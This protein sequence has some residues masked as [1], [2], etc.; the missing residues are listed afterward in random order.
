LASNFQGLSTTKRHARANGINAGADGN[1]VG[2]IVGGI[3]EDLFG[4]FASEVCASLEHL[5][6]SAYPLCECLNGNNSFLSARGG[7]GM[8]VTTQWGMATAP[9]PDASRNAVKKNLTIQ[10]LI[11]ALPRK[12]CLC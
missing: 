9:S 2:G 4:M 7:D 8:L 12:C 10:I 5:H 3:D 1:D 11:S 6:G